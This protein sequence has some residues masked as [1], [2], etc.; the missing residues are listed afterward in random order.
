MKINWFP[1]THLNFITHFAAEFV[2]QSSSLAMLE[3]ACRHWSDRNRRTAGLQWLMRA[4]NIFS[5]V[6]CLNIWSTGCEQS[7]LGAWM[8]NYARALNLFLSLRALLNLPG[9]LSTLH[10]SP[11]RTGIC[12]S[13]IHTSFHE[14][15]NNSDLSIDSLVLFRPRC[16][17]LFSIYIRERK[18][19]LY[20]LNSP[21]SA[22]SGPGSVGLCAAPLFAVGNKRLYSPAIVPLRLVRYR[23]L[24]HFL[25][26]GGAQSNAH[27][28]PLFRRGCTR[29]M[30][31]R[32]CGP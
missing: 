6:T 28:R 19:F 11:R 27:R 16:T 31:E 29:N 26:I 1:R 21:G 3:F 5:V 17:L 25:F 8:N 30:C 10:G 7:A 2:I 22:R 20:S 13:I 4:G 23:K 18:S 15:T 32:A 24:F 12:S 9:G 14:L